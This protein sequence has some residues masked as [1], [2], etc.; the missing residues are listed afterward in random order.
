V[1]VKEHKVNRTNTV[2]LPHLLCGADERS[3]S[4]LGASDFPCDDNKMPP[5]A[6]HAD[7]ALSP[8]RDVP[9]AG[10][11]TA[12]PC[13]IDYLIKNTNR[14]GRAEREDH[15]RSRSTT[16]AGAVRPSPPS[17]TRSPKLLLEIANQHR[18]Q[19][20]CR[21]SGTRPAQLA[22]PG[23]PR[24]RWATFRPGWATSRQNRRAHRPPRR[25]VRSIVRPALLGHRA[26]VSRT[27][28]ITPGR[29]PAPLV[30]AA[31]FGP[32]LVGSAAWVR[33]WTPP[34]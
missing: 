26:G 24:T 3:G 13:Q 21:P 7:R 4:S 16:P 10:G 19:G 20:S 34:R 15:P 5:Y 8:A 11:G 33:N 6:D 14:N 17:P 27:T 22:N 12:R 1:L 32:R 29:R 30:G 23:H 18:N 31:A 2:V 9:A 28:L 25:T